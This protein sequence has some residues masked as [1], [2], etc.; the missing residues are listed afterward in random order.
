MSITNTILCVGTEETVAIVTYVDQ[1]SRKATLVYGHEKRT[2]QR[3]RF[4]VGHGAVLKI[5]YITELDGNLRVLS[6]GRT[7]FPTDL[8]YAKVV[9]GTVRKRTDKDFAFLK[10]YDGDFYISSNLVRKHDLHDNEA[11]KS[12]IVLDYN[13]KKESWEWTCVSINKKNN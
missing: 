9:E 5:N 3:L 1:N 2:S 8:D 10:T 4:K 7:H 6:A 13:R 12:L 11:I